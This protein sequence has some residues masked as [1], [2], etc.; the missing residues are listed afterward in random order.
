[1]IKIKRFHKLRYITIFLLLLMPVCNADEV[2]LTDLLDAPPDLNPAI[3]SPESAIGLKVGERHWYHHEIIGYLNTLADTSDRITALGVHAHSYGGRDLVTYAISTPENLAQLDEIRSV[4]KDIVDPQANPDLSRQPAIIHMMYSIHGNEPSGGNVT[5][6]VAYYLAATEDPTIIAQLQ[7][8]VIIFNPILNPD[9]HDRFAHWTNSHR[10]QVPSTDPRDREHEEAFPG[11]R[12]NYYWFDLNR[13]WLPHQHPESRGRLSVFH[14]WKPNV[15]LDFHEQGS[16]NSYFFQPGKPER[17][18]PLTPDKNQELTDRIA[19]Y[20]RRV[21]DKEGVLYYSEE[22]YDDFFMG[23]G[24]TYPDLFGSVGI[25][26]EQASARGDRQDTQNGLLTFPVSIAN[27]FRT[28]MSSIEATAA[29]RQELLSYQRQFYID[30]AEQNRSRRG[31]YLART[32]GDPTRFREFIDVM[33]G[34]QIEV[35]VVTED[36]KVGGNLYPAGESVAIPAAQAHASYLEAIWESMVEFEE[37]VFYD[38]ST[39]TIPWAFNMT[40]T[41]E[42]IRNVQTS[43]LP[44]DFLV[45]STDLTRNAVGYLIDWRDSAS[46]ALLYG[47][48]DAGANIRVATGPLTANIVEHGDMDF[49]YGT[50]F[51]SKA[52]NDAIPSAAM[53]LLDRAASNGGAVYPVASSATRPGID[54]GSRDFKVLTKPKVLLVTGPGISAYSAG[55]IWHL[56]DQRLSM[57]L[58]MVDSPRLGFTPLDDYTHVLLVSPV[59]SLNKRGIDALNRFVRNG[60]VLFAQ[61]DATVRWLADNKITSADWRKTEE[62][63]SRDARQKGSGNNENLLPE[64]RPFSEARDQAAFKLVR[65][66]IL[67][68]SLDITHPLGYGYTSERLPMFRRSARFMDRSENAYSSP[69]IYTDTPLLSG[70]ISEENKRLAAGSAGLVVDQLGDGAIVQSLDS[71]TFRAFW[72]GTQRLLVNAIFFGDLLEEP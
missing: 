35:Q 7:D 42:P 24:S 55:E 9:G 10:G 4:R 36:T 21:F 43:A 5:P 30:N 54:M 8:V 15:Q 23:K 48:L 59:R 57:P 27:Q 11:G 61:G 38:V 40:H 70:Y 64:R 14:E 68:G 20:H 2:S 33:R 45:R 65:G 12:T 56:F 6:L 44:D 46:P 69:L 32:D 16:N 67:E 52:L 18:H 63:R 13:D 34:H 49:G 60:G 62:E 22:V 72:W 51:V 26:F 19:E 1:M 29:L 47:L 41:R 37:N 25:L 50:L 31:H 53:D 71:L 66:A 58:T 17:T 3:P 28:S 39:W